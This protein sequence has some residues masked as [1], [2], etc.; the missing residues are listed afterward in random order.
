MGISI[1]KLREFTNKCWTEDNFEESGIN[2]VIQ[3]QMPDYEKY[4]EEKQ[5]VLEVKNK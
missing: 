4:L 3:Q 1:Q 5:K 2:L